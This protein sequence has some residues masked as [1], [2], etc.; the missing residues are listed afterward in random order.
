MSDYKNYFEEVIGYEHIK[1]ELCQVVDMY[2][3]PDKY[4]R[5]GVELVH[6]IVL[7]GK[8]GIGKNTLAKCVANAMDA[9]VHIIRKDRAS[10]QIIEQVD[11]LLEE[12]KECSPA[13]IWLQD[14]DRFADEE[15]YHIYPEEVAAICKCIGVAR[16]YN[17]LVIAT[18]N[19]QEDD[20]ETQDYTRFGSF[21]K[22]FEIEFPTGQYVPKIITSYLNSKSLGTEIDVVECSRIMKI[23]GC[24]ELRKIVN[25]AGANAAYEDRTCISQKDMMNAYLKVHYDMFCND[26]NAVNEANMRLRALHEAGHAV[27]TECI[28]PGSVNFVTIYNNKSGNGMGGVSSAEGPRPDGKRFLEEEIMV[29]LGGKAAVEVVLG[30]S[31]AGSNRDMYKCFDLATKV[32]D[33]L[34]TY[35]FY[36]WV[37]DENTANEVQSVRHISA[38]TVVS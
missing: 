20:E 25:E 35:S 23:T 34:T 24:E 37:L 12:I 13:I 17:V 16:R 11:K 36:S 26:R 30:I 19:T 9:P 31:D 21:D 8:L 5:L 3:N 2:S 7:K 27:V 15:K 18:F 10:A 14:L 33:D 29:A 28:N 4:K 1:K 6:S 22:E 32:V 38:A